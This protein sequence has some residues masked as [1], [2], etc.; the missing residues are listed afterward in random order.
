MTV[1]EPFR[2]G[3]T[4]GSPVGLRVHGPLRDVAQSELEAAVEIAD[5]IPERAFS[6]PR[7]RD[8]IALARFQTA[9]L[10]RSEGDA[11]V[12]YVIA[13]EAVFLQGVRDELR[14]RFA[15]H[16]AWFLGSAREERVRLFDELQDLYDARSRIVHGTALPPHQI[17]AIA[18]LGRR[19][20]S[21]TLLRAL[22]NGW[23]SSEFLADA[24]FG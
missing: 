4:R 10:E 16:G 17:E 15:L 23:P 18:A 12:D 21:T 7:T 24:V 9:V 13:L 11:I 8:E 19:L 2:L 1:T 20:S 14:F 6:G 22:R 3:G 5:R